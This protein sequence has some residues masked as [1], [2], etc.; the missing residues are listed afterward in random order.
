MKNIVIIGA[1]LSGL[2]AGNILKNY[3]NVTLLEKSRGVSG[4]M[5][6]RRC[7]PYFFDHGAQFFKARTNE[8]QSFIAPMIEER[9]IERWNARFVEIKDKEIIEKQQ[10]GK[11]CPHYVG[12]PGMNAIGKYLSQGLKTQ[13]GKHV[14]SIRKQHGK[15]ILEDS[16]GNEL[17]KYDWAVSAAPAQQASIFLPSS[18]PFFPKVNAVKMKGCF[19]LMLGFQ[20]ALPLEF[21]AALVRGGDIHWVSVNNSKP[22]RNDVFC[23]LIHSTNSWADDHIDDDPNWILNDLCHQTSEIIGYDISK[24]DHKVI[25]RWRY[26]N[27]EKQGSNTHFIDR[28]EKIGI[29]GDWFIQG[30]VEAAFTSGFK[31]AH[32]IVK[33]LEK[34]G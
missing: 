16:Q 17:G 10:W 12:V 5:S 22:G 9:V 31:L 19:S 4:R 11:D 33:E 3:A 30:C 27:T 34:S 8:F 32:D 23:L 13:L 26:A 18:L 29:C 20:G 24:A 6:T 15:W 7:E 25:H 14:Q 21:D 28:N 1:G 2:T